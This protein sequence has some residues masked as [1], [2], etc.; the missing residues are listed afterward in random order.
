MAK[1]S[2]IP[3]PDDGALAWAIA[4]PNAAADAVR[5]LNLLLGLQVRL[6]RAGLSSLNQQ[7]SLLKS[8][9]VIQLALPLFWAAG[10]PSNVASLTSTTASA[11]YTQAEMQA[12]MDSVVSLIAAV[13]AI[14][15][16]ERG[17]QSQ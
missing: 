3:V 15:T 11:G 6:T 12:V 9:E 5:S 16:G 13:N 1:N 14:L 4:N 2:P 10:V 17:V 7:E 8:P